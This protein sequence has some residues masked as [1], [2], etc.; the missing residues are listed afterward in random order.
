MIHLGKSSLQM[1]LCQ[2]LCYSYSF[3]DK[4]GHEL[5]ECET[6]EGETLEQTDKISS[7]ISQRPYGYICKGLESI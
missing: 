1:M 2:C 4:K 7:S 6:L 5:S 3:Q